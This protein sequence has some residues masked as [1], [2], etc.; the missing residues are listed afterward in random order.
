MEEKKLDRAV[1]NSK[2]FEGVVSQKSF[3]AEKVSNT[4]T[5]IVNYKHQYPAMYISHLQT[6]HEPP[7]RPV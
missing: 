7:S 6:A 4:C 1:K 3:N 5:N 2:G